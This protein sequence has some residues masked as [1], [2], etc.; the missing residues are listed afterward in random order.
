MLGDVL[1]EDCSSVKIRV[2]EHL[3]GPDDDEEDETPLVPKAVRK[4][5][6]DEKKWQ[7]DLRLYRIG[8]RLAE[9]LGIGV[10]EDFNV[11]TQVVESR[12][13][14]GRKAWR[15]R[16]EG[17]FAWS[18]VARRDGTAVV[19]KLSKADKLTPNPLFG[20][21]EIEVE[22]KRMVAEYEPDSDLSDFEH[23]PLDEPGGMASFFSREVL[24]YAP[25]AW[26][27]QKSEKIGFEISFTRHFYKPV[28]LRPLSEI[29]TDIRK[30]MTESDQLG[31]V[32]HRG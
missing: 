23:V 25:D 20:Q 29:E 1:F 15:Y 19:K 26:I 11:F 14:L 9:D 31:S 24:Q 12:R 22:G 32:S 27:D 10:F 18:F 2:E 6:L 13:G 7:R 4:R 5:L 28:S 8:A 21:F 16:Q 17:S 30:L 3:E